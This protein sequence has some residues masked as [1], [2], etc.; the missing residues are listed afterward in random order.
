MVISIVGILSTIAF[1]SFSGYAVKARDSSRISDMANIVRVLGLSY[2]KNERYP[3]IETGTGVDISYSG[4]TL[5]TQGFF[6]E[7]IRV[8]T[9][10][11]S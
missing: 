7:D 4:S 1:V 5:W 9:Q 8:K 10:Q 2:L 6:D 11:L 3:K